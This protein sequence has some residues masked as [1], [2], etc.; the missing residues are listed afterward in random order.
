[1]RKGWRETRGENREVRNE[2]GGEKLYNHNVAKD[3]P[4]PGFLP[5]T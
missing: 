2:G 4:A 3:I 5:A 1:M